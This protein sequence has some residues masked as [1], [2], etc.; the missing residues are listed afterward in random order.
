MHV[1]NTGSVPS[2]A[3]GPLP[4]ASNDPPVASEVYI[5]SIQVSPRKLLNMCLC[6]QNKSCKQETR[7][8]VIVHLEV[9]CLPCT[10]K[11]KFDPGS[12]R[13]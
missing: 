4:I 1:V 7:A 13:L 11:S 5:L 8:G 9:Q 6:L 12:Y 10:K 3:Y 2:S